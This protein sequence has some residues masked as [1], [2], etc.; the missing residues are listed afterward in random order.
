MS[1]DYV[2][3]LSQE[4]LYTAISILA[5]ILGSALLVG[6]AVGIFQAITSIQEMTLTFIPKIAVVGLVILLLMPRFID[7]IL[8]FMVEIFNQ[9]ATMGF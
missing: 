1:T 5:P 9:I 7:N 8:S 6:L 4:T 2:I 3:Y